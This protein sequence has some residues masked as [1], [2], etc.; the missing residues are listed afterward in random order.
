MVNHHLAPFPQ[1][2]MEIQALPAKKAKKEETVKK[3][4]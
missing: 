1:G 4:K 2:A 3:A